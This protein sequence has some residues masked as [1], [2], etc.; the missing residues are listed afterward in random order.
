MEYIIL[1]TGY[2]IVITISFL[3]TKSVTKH[4]GAWKANF[5]FLFVAILALYYLFDSIIHQGLV[6]R[7]PYF[8]FWLFVCGAEMIF[9]LKGLKQDRS[10]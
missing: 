6:L 4:L 8:Y 7:N 9:F 1:L 3:I 10:A 2:L 5:V